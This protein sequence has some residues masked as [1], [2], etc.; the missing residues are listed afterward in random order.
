M[1]DYDL[2][3]NSFLKKLSHF[4]KSFKRKYIDRKPNELLFLK[5]L[6]TKTNTSLV[7][8]IGGNTCFDLFSTLGGTQ[9]QI[10]NYDPFEGYFEKPKRQIDLEIYLFK[11]YWQFTGNYTH[12]RKY[13]KKLEDI[14]N[15]DNGVLMIN[16]DTFFPAFQTNNKPSLLIYSHYRELP[17]LNSLITE[18][19]P[20]IH[21]LLPLRAVSYSMMY[22]CENAVSDCLPDSMKTLVTNGSFGG[23]KDVKLISERTGKYKNFSAIKNQAKSR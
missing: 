21:P 15:L 6:F 7:Q 18:H 4:E 14:Q 2:Y 17:C 23:C 9:S 11:K 13:I 3:D 5:N 20:K 12:K 16:D 22:F 8:V 19:I 10:I 1:I